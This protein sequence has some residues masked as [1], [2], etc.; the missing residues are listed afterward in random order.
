MKVVDAV[1]RIAWA[2][3]DR[4]PM[5]VLHALVWI[6]AALCVCALPFVWLVVEPYKHVAHLLRNDGYA[7]PC[8]WCHNL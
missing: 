7:C 4:T 5:W 6:G 1:L 3:L 2:V 8:A